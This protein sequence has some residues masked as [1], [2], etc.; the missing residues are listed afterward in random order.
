METCTKAPELRALANKVIKK[1]KDLFSLIRE[2]KISIGYCY[3]DLEKKKANGRTFAECRKV[4]AIYK[5]WLRYDFII[6]FYEPN[7]MLMDE[8]QLEILMQHELMHIGIS[9]DGKLMIVPHDIEDFRRIIDDYGL[10]WSDV[11]DSENSTEGAE[12]GE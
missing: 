5:T 9:D 6:V 1:N 10:D 4:P 7:T 2:Q 3:S 12:N 11:G 8:E